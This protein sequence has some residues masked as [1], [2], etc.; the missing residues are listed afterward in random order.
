MQG[1]MNFP[2]L[3]FPRPLGTLGLILLAAGTARADLG[4]P[5]G[6]W[7]LDASF[8]GALPAYPALNASSLTAG[9]DY[10]FA[11]DGAGY[12]FLQTQ[13]FATPAKRL[14]VANNAG[15]NGGPGA[16]RT[17]QWTVVM[18]VKF[19]ALQPYAGFLQL[20]PANLADVTFYISS[21]NNLTG[22]VNAGLS[23]AGAIAVNTWYRLA[24]TCGNNGAGGGTT[25]KLYLNGLPNG[26]PRTGTFNGT[27]SLQS[28]LH[29]FSDNNAELKPAKLGALGLWG[30]ELS[31]TDIA[32]LGAPQ[33]DGILPGGTG[34]TIAA[35]APYAYGANLGWIHARPSSSTGVVIGE[36][37]CSGNAHSANCGWITLGDGSPASGIRYS[38]TDGTDSGVNHDGL[39]NLSGLAYGANIGWIN[40]GTDETGAPRPLNDPY[41]PR[42]SLSTG[43]FAGFAHG[44]NVGWID[45]ATLRTAT[46]ACPDT[47]H[48]G[49]ADAWEWENFAGLTT[50][51][52][53]SDFDK[54][55]ATD[56]NE[57]LALTDPKNGSSSLHI[58]SQTLGSGPSAPWDITFT[59]HPGR[60]YQ[61]GKSSLLTPGSWT[62][63]ALFAPDA[64]TQT[65]RTIIESGEARDFLRVT[66][67][68]PLQP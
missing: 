54:D 38:N 52:A 2:T 40:F 31:A 26:T 55:G 1:S 59:S 16:T 51:N 25:V 11:S 29:L 28:T 10:N 14:A 39:G 67:V 8:A 42:F 46:L 24:I 60:L 7:Q 4:N 57:Y 63:S 6:L 43:Q 58:I 50:A 18:D 19:D 21:T 35:D 61:I 56:Q 22:S 27:L 66:A 15:A 65:T 64:G 17:N 48:D 41:R 36:Y 37:V 13:I 45:L 34:S 9:T 3:S 20:D 62:D 32:A 23:S 33:P 30:E 5:Q 44:A 53:T 68:K 47:D 12:Q 49:L